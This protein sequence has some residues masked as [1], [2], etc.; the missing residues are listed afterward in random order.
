ME[1]V[2][3]GNAVRDPGL[4]DMSGPEDTATSHS[5]RSVV[6]KLV[7][8]E[9]V[10]KHPERRRSA[11]WPTSRRSTEL[12]CANGKKRKDPSRS[13]RGVFSRELLE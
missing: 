9:N 4:A 6:C 7:S 10:D 1:D 12:Q 13:V 3:Q 8:Q 5:D 2:M 11:W